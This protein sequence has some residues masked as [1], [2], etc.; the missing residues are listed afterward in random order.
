MEKW[1]NHPHI[2]INEE[3]LQNFDLKNLASLAQ[4]IKLLVWLLKFIKAYIIVT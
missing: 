3:N 2:S 1:V 4:V